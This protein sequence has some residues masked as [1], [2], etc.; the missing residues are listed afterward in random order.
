MMGSGAMKWV[1]AFAAFIMVNAL[2]SCGNLN[3]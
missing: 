2:F 3:G 1:L